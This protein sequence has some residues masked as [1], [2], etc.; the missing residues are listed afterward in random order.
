MSIQSPTGILDVTNATLRAGKLE[1]TGDITCSSNLVVS[2]GF[3]LSAINSNADTVVDFTATR[4]LRKYPREILTSSSQNG[5]LVSNSAVYPAAIYNTASNAFIESTTGN[6]EEFLSANDAFSTSA[7]YDATANYSFNSVNGP[8]LKLKLPSA[9]E[10]HSFEIFGRT[11]NGSHISDLI[12]DG[13]VWASNDDSTWT[14]VA[15]LN[16]LGVYTNSRPATVH[17]GSNVAYSYFTIHITSV[18]TQWGYASVGEWKLYGYESAKGDGQDVRLRAHANAPNTDFLEVHFD[19]NVSNSYPGNGTTLTD[20]SGEAHHATLNNGVGFDSTYGALTFNGSNQNVNTQALGISGDFVHTASL[21]V[22]PGVNQSA[23]SATN[24]VA[25]FYIGP[26]SYTAEQSIVVSYRKD[27]LR[28]WFGG[29]DVDVTTDFK[30]NE[31]IHLAVVYRGGGGTA[32]NRDVYVN[33]VKQRYL[34][35][36]GSSYGNALNVQSTA[37]LRLGAAHGT[38]AAPDQDFNGSI[39][40]FRLFKR[41]LIEAEIH[42][43][44]DWEKV[45][46]ARVALGDVVAFRDGSLGVGVAE[47]SRDDRLVVDG[48]VKADS[49]KVGTLVDRNDVVVYEQTPYDRPLTKYPEIKIS[50][51]GAVTT[52]T[53]GGYTLTSSA[54][55]NN[56]VAYALSNAF[57]GNLTTISSAWISKYGGFTNPTNDGSS[58]VTPAT[59]L[60][61]F[62]PGTGAINGPWLK[63]ELPSPIRLSYIRLYKWAGS[64]TATIPSAGTIYGSNDGSNFTTI[65]S[66]TGIHTSLLSGPYDFNLNLTQT[67]KYYVIHFTSV[68]TVYNSHYLG[69]Q[70]LELYGTEEGDVSTDSTW[71]SVLNKP[72]TQQLEVYWDGAD[73]NSYPGAGTEV[74]DLSGNDLTGAMTGVEFDSVYNSFYFDTT[75]DDRITTTTSASGAY[76]HSVSMW[77]KFGELGSVQHYIAHLGTKGS[78]LTFAGMYYS[79]NYGIRV[80]IGNEYRTKYHPPIGEWIHVTYTYAGGTPDSTAGDVIVKFYVNGERVYFTGYYERATGALALPSSSVFQ[81]TGSSD[82]SG[83]ANNHYES[84]VGNARLF[85]KALSA[86]QVKELYA[87]DAVRFGHRASNSVSVHKGNLGIG[88]NYP[89]SRFEVA[90]REDLQEYPPMAM[91][92]YETYMEGHGVFKAYA[93]SEQNGAAWKAFNKTDATGEGWVTDQ[94]EFVLDTGY[95]NTLTSTTN[96][97]FGRCSFLA[98]ETPGLIKLEKIRI[99]PDVST[100]GSPDSHDLGMPKDFQIWARKSGTDWT[101]IAGYYDQTFLYLTGSTEYYDVNATDYYSEFAIVVTRTHTS[102][103]YSWTGGTSQYSRGSISEWRLFGTPAPTTLDDGHLTLGK[104]LTTPRVSGHAAGAETPRAESLVVHYDTTVDSVV[105]GNTVVDT[106]GAGNNGAFNGNPVYS[107]ADRA[108]QFDG[109]GDYISTP[110]SEIP[111]SDWAFTVSFWMKRTSSSD[112]VMSAAT[113]IYIGDNATH[114]GIG[115][116]IYTDSGG[117]ANDVYWFVHGGKYKLWDQQA[118][119]MFP[120]NVWVHVAVTHAVG[121]TD[122]RLYINGVEQTNFTSGGS[123]DVAFDAGDTVNIGSRDNSQHFFGDVSNIKLWGGI[124]LTPAEIAAE[125]ALGRTGKALNVIDTAV[126]LGGTVP[127]AQLDVRGSAS[128]DFAKIQNLQ[129]NGTNQKYFLEYRYQNY[130]TS[131]NNQTFT[132]P[133]TGL[134]ARGLMLVEAKVIQVAPNSSSERVARVKGMIS[135][136]STGNFYMTVV[137]GENVSAFETYMAGA[138]GNAGGTFTMT[139]RPVAGYQQSVVCK[140]YLKIFIGGY[141]SSLGSLTRTDTGSNTA[142]QAPTFNSAVTSIGGNLEMSGKQVY[143]M[144]RWEIDLTSQ[145]NSNFYPIEFTHPFVT[146]LPDMHP[147][148]FKVF[149]QALSGSDPYNENTLVGYAKGGGWSDHGPM[150]DVHIRRYTKGEHRFQGLYEGTGG[151]YQQIVIYMRGGYRYSAITDATNVVTHT[152]AYTVPNSDGATFA[153]KDS[154]GTDVSGTSSAI[155][156]LVN[157]AANARHAERFTSGDFNIDGNVGISSIGLIETFSGTTAESTFDNSD[158]VHLTT[159]GPGA[160]M[161]L[162]YADYN[163]YDRTGARCYTYAASKNVSGGNMSVDMDTQSLHISSTTNFN[164]YIVITPDSGATAKVYIRSSGD[165]SGQNVV[166]KVAMY[167]LN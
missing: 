74:F 161:I 132:I 30:A 71:T 97:V 104:Q 127:R 34:R 151:A 28:Y 16:A 60:D 158:Q 31:W 88:V 32:A 72:G 112:P 92:G 160:G 94:H 12:D 66:F 33:G 56:T 26:E 130:W 78:T 166:W 44:Y 139:Y 156:Q 114:Q 137:E 58:H 35:T 46:F 49:A 93:N 108:V 43:L 54:L 59:S 141:T 106:S 121:F 65:T 122:E 144:L 3:D 5:Y 100:S 6:G 55:Y 81:V 107:S 76:V 157:L 13:Y 53:Q 41:P 98:L 101:R 118:M 4:Q 1:S 90:G 11:F 27:E 91:T 39:A 75:N 154:S 14:Q 20:L 167:R 69:V 36:Y 143:P 89:N 37:F 29:N 110:V 162:M 102:T 136:Y 8:W 105:S 148:H 40:N 15:R 9:I 152:S 2:G 52:T 24:W 153:I 111:A 129:V 149:G 84:W 79:D 142:L 146:G 23:L 45:R 63:V 126:C 61:T 38:N 51:V 124:N 120:V 150:Y 80:V 42:Q 67:Y 133:V 140:M 7:P 21:W 19:A 77:V 155:G 135:N 83:A 22:K 109:S 85:S 165:R 47:P 10:L 82:S 131:N 113:P 50:G 25:F 57:D 73:S 145:S 64:S 70:E 117:A 68:Y 99:Q 62:N 115:L 128:F 119:T 18:T 123:G 138:S 87:Y 86:E 134:S 48:R 164:P 96:T 17:V 147:I 125:Y 116:D 95:S 159:I 163:G 103:S